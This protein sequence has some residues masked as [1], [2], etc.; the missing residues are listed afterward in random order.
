MAFTRSPDRSVERTL[1]IAATRALAKGE[2]SPELAALTSR[3]L[4]WDW[5][6]NQAEAERVAALL[7]SVARSLAVPPPVLERLRATWV[8]G[9]RQYLLG[10]EQLTRVLALFEQV[11]VPVIPLRGPTLADLLY[12]DPALRPFTDLDLLIPEGDLSRT[13]PLL[14][15]LGYGHMETSLPLSHELNWRHAASFTA[16]NPD[17]LPIDL[18]WGVVDYPVIAPVARINHQE[19][20]ARAVRVE[21]QGGVRWELCP[22]DL[23]ISLALHWAVHHALSG[24][25]WQLDLALLISRTGGALDWDAVV[26]RA[27][28]WRIRGPVFF[29]LQE[30]RD[31]LEA[32]V[33]A[34]VLARLRRAG[35]R[36]AV[37][38]WLR[39]RG[40]ERLERLDYLFPFLIMD[41]GS[42]ILRALLRA[43]LPPAAWLRDRYGKD[44]LL[45]A[46]LAH[47]ARIGKVWTRTARASFP[48]A[49]PRR[50]TLRS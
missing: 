16:N 29:A 13:L 11:G 15:A 36:N 35:P 1:L 38:N 3:P 9:R 30:V 37:L 28:R 47:Y 20:W 2:V 32:A 4:D 21:G 19:L 23:L 41:R 31:R 12:R 33:P 6:L 40:E 49:K 43:G 5:I 25:V 8:K 14:A 45:E 48:W 34:A 42:D 50:F 26:E 18:H 44:A 22:E 46:Y 39:H 10:V 7:Y 27:G 24:L 17:A